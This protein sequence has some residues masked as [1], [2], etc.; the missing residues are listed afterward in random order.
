VGETY[1]VRRE[2]TLRA[3]TTLDGK[4]GFRSKSQNLGYFL[5]RRQNLLDSRPDLGPSG[6]WELANRD[7]IP[8]QQDVVNTINLEQSGSDRVILS[9]RRVEETGRL[10]RYRPIQDELLSVRIGRRLN[11]P[12]SEGHAQPPRLNICNAILNR[13]GRN[14]VLVKKIKNFAAR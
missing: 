12:H 8:K 7:E 2:E 14:P 9:L 5:T 13:Y 11:F 1:G 3:I 6:L 10:L 4:T